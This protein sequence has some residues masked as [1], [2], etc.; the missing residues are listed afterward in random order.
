LHFA[1]IEDGMNKRKSQR[2]PISEEK[3]RWISRW[4]Q[5]LVYEARR[6]YRIPL[7]E[8]ANVLRRSEGTVSLMWGRHRNELEKRPETQHLIRPLQQTQDGTTGGMQNANTVSM[9]CIAL[10]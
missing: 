2:L 9:P 5:A 4:R 3:V 10:N 7:V 1:F 8:I 6:Y